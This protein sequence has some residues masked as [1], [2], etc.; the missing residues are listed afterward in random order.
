MPL[1][2]L[3]AIFGGAIL[4]VVGSVVGRA[5]VALGVGAVSYV[6]VNA[7][8]SFLKAQALSA[9]STLPPN[10]VSML[11]LLKVGVALNIVISAILVRLTLNGLTGD[12]FRRWVLK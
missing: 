3:G 12:T 2:A 1:P 11:S 6:G 4:N 9:I 5:L 10:I 8:I 7:S